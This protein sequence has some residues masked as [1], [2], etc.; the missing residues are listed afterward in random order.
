MLLIDIAE[1]TEHVFNI[2][3]GLR[4]VDVVSLRKMQADSRKSARDIGH[5]RMRGVWI[6]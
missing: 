1:D 6:D 3:D 4:D 5:V 2:R